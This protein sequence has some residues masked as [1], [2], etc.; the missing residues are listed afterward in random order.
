MYLKMYI[1]SERFQHNQTFDDEK[2]Y[3]EYDE[4]MDDRKFT[5]YT[6]YNCLIMQRFL[7]VYS[8]N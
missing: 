2:C 4:E 7:K 6:K 3:S 1:K 5:F 8:A